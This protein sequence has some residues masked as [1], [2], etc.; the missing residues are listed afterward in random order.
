MTSQLSFLG[1][2][3]FCHPGKAFRTRKVF[4]VIRIEMRTLSFP[5]GQ[6]PGGIAGGESGKKASRRKAVSY[7]MGS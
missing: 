1:D 4:L 6:G 2:K 3:G 7:K 5:S